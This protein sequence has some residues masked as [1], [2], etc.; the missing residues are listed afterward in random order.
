MGAYAFSAM[1]ALLSL[2][3]FPS[4]YSGFAR[5]DDMKA[6][7][8][9]YTAQVSQVAQKLQAKEDQDNKYRAQQLVG[10]I[11]DTQEKLCRAK[12]ADLKSQLQ[13]NIADQLQLYR[14]LSGHALDHLPACGEL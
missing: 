14:D 5:G 2:G 9:Q 6:F 4:I 1:M 11:I 12:N 13:R 7:A 3:I 10:Q 8:A